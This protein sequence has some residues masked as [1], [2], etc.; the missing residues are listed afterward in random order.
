MQSKVDVVNDYNVILL[1]NIYKPDDWIAMNDLFTM[2]N[3]YDIMQWNVLW[4]LR[5]YLSLEKIHSF[6]KLSNNS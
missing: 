5:K 3:E 4:K 6:D 1:H 2:K